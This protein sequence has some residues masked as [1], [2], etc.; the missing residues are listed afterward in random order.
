MAFL[1][2]FYQPLASVC[3][4]AEFGAKKYGYL[5]WQECEDLDR[6]RHALTRHLFAYLEGEWLDKDHGQPHLAAVAWNALV[7]MWFKEK[8]GA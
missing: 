4:V 7:L 6:Y 1:G 5:N 3:R 2:V 8:R